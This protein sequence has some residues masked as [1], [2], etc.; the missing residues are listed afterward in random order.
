MC[1][2][3]VGNLFGVGPLLFCL[4]KKSL[5]DPFSTLIVGELCGEK[6]E[7]MYLE[8]V[9]MEEVMYSKEG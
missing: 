5:G 1:I 8:F 7:K 6:L 3:V 9:G 4:L 2:W